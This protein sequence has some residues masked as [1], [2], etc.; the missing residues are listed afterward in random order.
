MLGL[1]I[2]GNAFSGACQRYIYVSGCV[3]SC[4]IETDIRKELP[5][6]FPFPDRSILP[7]SAVCTCGLEYYEDTLDGVYCSSGITNSFMA[8]ISEHSPLWLITWNCYKF[9]DK[10][11]IYHMN[12]DIRDGVMVI[13]RTKTMDQHPTVLI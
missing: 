5:G 13:T 3:M 1:H 7:I 8:H 6:G 2:G 11:P 4:N 12:P 10:Y 9:D